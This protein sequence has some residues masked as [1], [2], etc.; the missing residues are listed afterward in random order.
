MA[1]SCLDV[2]AGKNKKEQNA[3]HLYRPGEGPNCVA[4]RRNKK[5]NRLQ[6]KASKKEAVDLVHREGRVKAGLFICC[7]RCS[8]TMECCR[9][10]YLTQGNLEK[11]QQKGKH[12][13]PGGIN[14]TNWLVLEASKPGGA[15]ASGSRPDRLKKSSVGASN[16]EVAVTGQLGEVQARCRGRFNRKKDGV[17]NYRKP[18]RLLQELKT[19]FDIEPKLRPHEM[20]ERMAAM[21]DPADGGLFFC[22]SKRDT[23][24]MLLSE[25]TI[26][27]WISSETQKR[28]KASKKGP[29]EIELEQALRIRELEAGNALQLQVTTL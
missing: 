2:N 8:T 29:T 11:H 25:D 3:S 4:V 28:K 5:H 1:P 26:A 21:I 20:K 22:Y 27:Q 23:N 24:G 9:K 15:V 13:F 18:K 12:K 19:L 17:N 10:V 6:A 16:V 14:A 7:G